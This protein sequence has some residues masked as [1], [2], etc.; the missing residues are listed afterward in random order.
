VLFTSSIQ[1]DHLLQIAAQRGIEAEVRSTLAQ[2][3]AVA[4]VGPIMTEALEAAGLPVDI[5]PLHPKMAGLVKASA[6]QAADALVRK[7]AT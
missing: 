5:V 1:L 7:R 4:S 3:A 2:Y 6:D